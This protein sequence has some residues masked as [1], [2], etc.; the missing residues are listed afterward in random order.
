MSLEPEY[1]TYPLR[2]HGYDHERYAWSMLGDRPPLR[3]PG[4]K[5]LA[6]WINVSLQFYPLNQRGVPFKVPNGMTMPYPDLRHY[7]LRDYG[8]RVGIYRMLAAFAQRGVRPTWAISAQLAEQTP[9][10][11]QRLKAYGG[12]FLCHGWNMDHL[13]Y[14]GQDRDEEAE[15]VRR[16]VSTLRELT[17]Q[18]VRGWLSPAKHQSWNTP[19]LLA[20]NGIEYCCDWVN[21]DLPYPF[22]TEQGALTMMPLSTEI[23]DQFVMCQNLHSE[24]SWA[25]QVRDAFDY[26]LQEGREQGG[27]LLAL[28]LHPWLVGQ[29]HR[30]GCLEA[31]LDHIVGHAEVWQAPAGEI[32]DAYRAQTVND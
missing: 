12:E 11:L 2:R 26:L 10:L 22:S 19:E 31:V 14:G 13:H 4:D 16:S 18:P 17:G 32:L 27:R 28:N 29:P 3:W 9:Y 15:I 8:N 23:E 1:L 6:V 25:T 5:P 20:E 24:E 21:D 30:I 7:S